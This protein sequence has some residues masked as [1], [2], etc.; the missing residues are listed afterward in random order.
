V[1]GVGPARA[2]VQLYYDGSE[3]HLA[4]RHLRF[5][6]MLCTSWVIVCCGAAKIDRPA[7]AGEMY[8]GSFHHMARTAAATLTSESRLL[9]LSAR[10]GLLRP[11]DV[12]E[13]YDL[14]LGQLGSATAADIREQAAEQ[15]LRVLHPLVV[16]A[17]RDYAQLARAIHW[18]LADCRGI[19]EQRARLADIA[20]TGVLTASAPAAKEM[21]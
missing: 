1:R 7:P 8:V 18:P 20:R 16:L 9:I 11:T 15:G 3:H 13:P 19:G 17:G 4:H 12:I 6:T 14:R 21:A 2:R 5:V 10:Y